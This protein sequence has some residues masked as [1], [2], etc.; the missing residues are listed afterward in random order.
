MELFG[1]L[2]SYRAKS[3]N[4]RNLGWSREGSKPPFIEGKGYKTLTRAR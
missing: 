4:P 2:F 3:L 1:T